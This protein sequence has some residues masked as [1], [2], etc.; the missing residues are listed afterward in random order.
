MWRFFRL[1]FQVLTRTILSPPSALSPS[2][3]S[4]CQVSKP[5]R[6]RS[7]PLSENRR[8][9]SLL[10]HS[11]PAVAAAAAFAIAS[12]SPLAAT[13]LPLPPL[14]TPAFFGL[15]RTLAE[16]AGDEE[17]ESTLDEGTDDGCG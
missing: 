15:A 13:A 8:Q 11:P 16:A 14:V 10:L 1:V 6:S 3:H 5:K 12:P 7:F 9:V 2:L 17:E 4:L